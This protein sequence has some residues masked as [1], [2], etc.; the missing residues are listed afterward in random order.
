[1]QRAH[2]ATAARIGWALRGRIWPRP[3]VKYGSRGTVALGDTPRRKR[4]RR[5]ASV[6]INAGQA[7]SAMRAGAPP[8]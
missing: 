1:M 5:P 2:L 8:S 4:E 6:G 3:G 7:D